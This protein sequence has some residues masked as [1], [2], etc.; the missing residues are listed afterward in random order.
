MCIR[1][2]FNCINLKMFVYGG[3]FTQL[4]ICGPSHKNPAPCRKSEF[5]F[6]A[7]LRRSKDTLFG[8]IREKKSYHLRGYTGQGF[9]GKLAE[10]HH[11]ARKNPRFGNFVKSDILRCLVK[12]RASKCILRVVMGVEGGKNLRKVE[13]LA[14]LGICKH[15]RQ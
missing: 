6:T 3:N 14:F 7:V 15:E 10:C 1:D 13:F 5:E 9:S 12:F 4:Q 11:N 2:R 8:E